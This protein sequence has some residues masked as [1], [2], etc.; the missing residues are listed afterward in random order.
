MNLQEIWE[1]ALGEIKLNISKA[2]Y[3]T[4]LKDT[5]IMD[6]RENTVFLGV[7]SSFTKEW[8]E[9]KYQ[10]QILGALFHLNPQ[11]K[12]IEYVVT[13]DK[14]A[15]KKIN[16]QKT[17][18]SSSSP[19]TSVLD[20]PL[21]LNIDPETNLNPKYTFENFIV[22]ANNELANAAALAITENLGNKY[23]PLFIYGGVGLGKTH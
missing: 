1:S 8:L 16:L 17:K 18:R 10:K 12:R 23:N 6:I 14:N 21:E 11:I 3:L 15:L 20:E 9:N 13:T 19:K 5:H 4:W 2:N 22:G 7:P